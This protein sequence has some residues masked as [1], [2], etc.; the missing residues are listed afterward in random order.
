MLRRITLIALVLGLTLNL[1]AGGLSL[2]NP[3]RSLSLLF[4]FFFFFTTA[5]LTYGLALALAMV[6]VLLRLITGWRLLYGRRARFLAT[7]R[8]NE[9]LL[10][11]FFAQRL[12]LIVCIALI[13]LIINFLLRYQAEMSIE[14]NMSLTMLILPAI[15]CIILLI[16]RTSPPRTAATTPDPSTA[17]G[18]Q[19]G[20]GS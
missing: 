12:V 13:P 18:Q 4:S 10:W 15:I 20:S 17:G 9:R 1:L 16:E 19:R 3:E 11:R 2:F 7:D 14:T 5:V 6:M 8:Y